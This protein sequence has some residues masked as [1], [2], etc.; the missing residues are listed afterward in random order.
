MFYGPTLRVI[1]PI[2]QFNCK[3]TAISGIRGNSILYNHLT[4]MEDSTLISLLPKTT[5][6]TTITLFKTRTC[7]VYQTL[8]KSAHCGKTCSWFHFNYLVKCPKTLVFGKHWSMHHGFLETLNKWQINVFSNLWQQS[9]DPF[10]SLV[11]FEFSFNER[12]RELAEIRGEKWL[13]SIV[14]PFIPN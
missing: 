14:N 4:F 13:K 3:E 10:H 1:P 7:Y 8:W 12:K 9:G 11:I 6:S 5:Y 2:F